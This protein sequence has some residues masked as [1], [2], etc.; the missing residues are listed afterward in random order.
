MNKHLKEIIYGLIGLAMSIG[1][2]YGM[3]WIAKT[4]S[5]QIFYEDMV[6][7]T[8]TEMVKPEYLKEI[9]Q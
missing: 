4:I 2:I 3:Y 7:R 9:N 1:F 6:Q 5:Y 8:V